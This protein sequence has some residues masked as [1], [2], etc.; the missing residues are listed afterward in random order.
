MLPTSVAVIIWG[1]GN[2][3]TVVDLNDTAF[4]REM[5]RIGGSHRIIWVPGP[6]ESWTGN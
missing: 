4:V 6:W 3:T 2:D 1:M 5:M